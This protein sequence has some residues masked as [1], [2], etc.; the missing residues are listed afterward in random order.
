LSRLI[1]KASPTDDD[2]NHHPTLLQKLTR[3]MTTSKPNKNKR[4]VG[5]QLTTS[6]ISG[7]ETD[8]AL[9]SPPTP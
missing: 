7:G 2:A 3:Q 5:N 8:L 6:L 4:A 9:S 1:V